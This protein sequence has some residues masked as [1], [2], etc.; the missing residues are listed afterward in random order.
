MHPFEIGL[1]VVSSPHVIYLRV[2]LRRIGPIAGVE[3]HLPHLRVVEP[4]HYDDIERQMALAVAVGD[5]H[6]L[7]LRAVALLRL[8]EAVRVFGG[9][10]A[11][12]VDSLCLNWVKFQSFCFRQH[13]TNEI[14]H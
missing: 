4:V 1:A 3:A 9:R 6:N 2:H 5:S 7:G 13:G 14:F 12:Q 8:D 10:T 11:L